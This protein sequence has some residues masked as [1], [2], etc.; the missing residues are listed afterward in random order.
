[1]GKTPNF[2]LP[3]PGYRG[4]NDNRKQTQRMG[5]EN[6]RMKDTKVRRG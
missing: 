5:K 2:L 1:M 3:F 6:R 4:R